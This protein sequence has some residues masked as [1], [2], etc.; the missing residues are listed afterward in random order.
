MF[1]HCNGVFWTRSVERSGEVTTFLEVSFSPE[2]VQQS[3]P[4]KPLS[5]AS[6]QKCQAGILDQMKYAP[7]IVA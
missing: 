3:E 4:R 5:F 1:F 7:N 6:A 2:I